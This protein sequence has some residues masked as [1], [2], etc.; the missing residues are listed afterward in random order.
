[1]DNSYIAYSRTYEYQKHYT[2]KYYEKNKHA[3]LEHKAQKYICGCGSFIR[4]GD[5]AIH[6]RTKKHQ[7]FMKTLDVCVSL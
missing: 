5:K 6:N 3:I 4:V 7:L 1:M 2:K